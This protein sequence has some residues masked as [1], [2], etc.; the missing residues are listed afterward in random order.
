MPHSEVSSPSFFILEAEFHDSI[1]CIWGILD[2]ERRRF[3]FDSGAQQAVLNAR[4]FRDKQMSQGGNAMGVTGEFGIHYTTID[5]LAFGEWRFRGL[6][7]MVMEMEH[8]EA[9]FG[10]EVHGLIGFKQM[11]HFDWMVDY[12][13]KQIHFWS[14]M[15]KADF[16][17]LSR[18]KARYSHHVPIIDLEIQGHAFRFL[19][20][21]GASM[22]L[23][24]A[25]KRELV[26]DA[27]TEIVSEPMASSSPVQVTVESG[28]LSGFT[29]NGIPYGASNIKFADLSILQRQIGDFDGVIGYPLLSQYPT[30]VSW[31]FHALFVLAKDAM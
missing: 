12:Q 3:L 17:I 28:T 19:V 22:V 9:E 30:V 15:H 24:D 27:V 2:G 23:F 29:V 25:Q 10:V 20:D 16:N 26:I 8:L 7:M 13:L 5:D 1:P 11:I 18:V 4:Y 14:R 31:N 21:T 6:E